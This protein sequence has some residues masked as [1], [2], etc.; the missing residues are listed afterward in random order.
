MWYFTRDFR[1]KRKEKKMQKAIAKRG[2]FHKN[3]WKIIN[4]IE[5]DK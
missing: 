2:E 1:R 5:S 3:I 4:I